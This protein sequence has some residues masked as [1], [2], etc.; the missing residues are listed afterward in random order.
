MSIQGIC[1]NIVVCIK[2]VPASSK[3]LIDP[4]TGVM[5]RDGNNVKMNPFDLV[6]CG[7][8][9]TDG[10]TAQVGPEIAEFLN[11]PHISYV[12]QIIEIKNNSIVVQYST[13]EATMSFYLS[14]IWGLWELAYVYS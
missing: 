3:V 4:E 9:T 10:D 14:F 8:Q 5:I 6:I 12:D 7:K 2:Q 1:M 11:M 13:D